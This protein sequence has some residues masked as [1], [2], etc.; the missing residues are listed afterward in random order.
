VYEKIHKNMTMG[1]Q[2]EG[3]HGNCCTRTDPWP[4]TLGHIHIL[5]E[6]AYSQNAFGHFC[7]GIQLCRIVGHSLNPFD[8]HTIFPQARD[9]KGRVCLRGALAGFFFSE[10]RFNTLSA[11]IP[12]RPLVSVL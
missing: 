11:F 12:S 8:A 3:K 6:N 9:Q 5:E 7:T 10:D 4:N 1:K 2:Q